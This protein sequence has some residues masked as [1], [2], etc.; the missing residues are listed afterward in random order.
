[1]AENS[2]GIRQGSVFDGQ[3][4]EA[5]TKRKKA[6]TIISVFVMY[7]LAS[8]SV[9]DSTKSLLKNIT[10]LLDD[11]LSQYD[12]NAVKILFFKMD[13]LIITPLLDNEN[14]HID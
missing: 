9:S 2:R 8:R 4:F 6:R 14:T 10:Y 1:M 5:N 13:F 3:T 7:L 12:E 11:I